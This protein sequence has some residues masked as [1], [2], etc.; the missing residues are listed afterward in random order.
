MRV[1]KATDAGRV[2]EK[3][4]DFYYVSDND[5]KLFIVADGMGRISRWRG[6]K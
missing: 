6:C 2:R 5:L 3:N 4:E 1:Y